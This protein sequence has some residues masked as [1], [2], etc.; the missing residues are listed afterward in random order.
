MADLRERVESD[1]TGCVTALRAVHHA[2]GYPSVWPA[3]PVGFLTPP[4]VGVWVVAD[5]GAILGH[6]LVLRHPPS[7]AVEASGLSAGAVGAVGRLFT[8]PAARGC[9][10]GRALLGAAVAR[11]RACGQVPILDVVS[12]ST[13]AVAL[14]ERTGWTLTGAGSAPWTDPDGSHAPVSYFVLRERA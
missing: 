3:D 9:G 12:A 7:P 8:V 13:A 14:Y 11:I 6:V 10:W 2:E 5:G 1:L 4:H